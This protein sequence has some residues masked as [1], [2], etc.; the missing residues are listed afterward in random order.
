MRDLENIVTVKSHSNESIGCFFRYC[1]P[2]GWDRSVYQL[3]RS[4]TPKGSRI[5]INLISGVLLR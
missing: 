5:K 3:E 2:F 1:L 4:I